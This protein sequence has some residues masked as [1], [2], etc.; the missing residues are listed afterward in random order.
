MLAGLL[1]CA[2]SKDDKGNDGGTPPP[3]GLTFTEPLHDWTLTRT[4][5]KNLE[6]RKI[7]YESSTVQDGDPTISYHGE[8]DYVKD[9]KYVF[10]KATDKL[11]YSKISFL[12]NSNVFDQLFTSMQQKYGS[13][14][15][16]DPDWAGINYIWTKNNL[17]ITLYKSSNFTTITYQPL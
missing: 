3:T 13:A 12:N 14:Y 10:L 1:L 15:E 2:C 11:R 5:V 4:Q 7:S 16:E 9:V 8:N 6:T 17:K